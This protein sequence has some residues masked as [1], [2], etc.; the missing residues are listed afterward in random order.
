MAWYNKKIGEAVK[1][2]F[3]IEEKEVVQV[4]LSLQKQFTTTINQLVLESANQALRNDA[5]TVLQNTFKNQKQI[6]D[7]MSQKGW[8]ATDA[9]NRQELDRAKQEINQLNTAYAN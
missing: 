5:V 4:I 6:F 3:S 1:M 2:T 8:Y 7:L 9:A